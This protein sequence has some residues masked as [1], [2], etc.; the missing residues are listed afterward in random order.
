M[1]LYAQGGT[2]VAAWVTPLDNISNLGGIHHIECKPDNEHVNL[3]VQGL[4]GN[5]DARVRINVYA[6]VNV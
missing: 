6:A 1:P 3:V 5:A 4:P 2:V